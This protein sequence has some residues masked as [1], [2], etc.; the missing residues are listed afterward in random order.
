MSN[1]E[2]VKILDAKNIDTEFYFLSLLEQAKNAN[3]ITD[4][5]I[6]KIQSSCLL[7]LK[8]KLH[9]LTNGES[10]SVRT[11]VAE[12]IMKSNLYTVGVFLKSFTD[13]VDAL[14]LLKT[15]TIPEIYK[16]SK[17][18]IDRLIKN[19]KQL[20]FLVRKNLIKT[21]NFAYVSTIVAGIKGFFK[22][23]NAEFHANEIP[24]TCDYPTLIQVKNVVGIEFIERY[25]HYIYYENTFSNLF[26]AEQ[27]HYLLCGYDEHYEDLIF[28]IYEQILVTAMGIAILK[29]NVKSLYLSKVDVENIYLLF[30]EKSEKE[31]SVIVQS[32]FH[33][34]ITNLNINNKGLEKYILKSM[35]QLIS[36]IFIAID[37][38]TID[39]LFITSVKKPP[40]E[41]V[42]FSAGERMDDDKFTALVEEIM[43]CRFISDKLLLIRNEVFSLADLNDIILTAE[44]SETEMTEIL[45]TLEPPE[46]AAFIK[47]YLS[48]EEIEAEN[49]SEAEI[50]FS[51]SLREYF[52]SLPKKTQIEIARLLEKI[53]VEF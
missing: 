1:I 47:E 6:E 16:L 24:I 53:E 51:K 34:M 18:R 52:V 8:D 26:S 15:K 20:Y 3:L 44:L 33:F 41:Q 48:N 25:L 21:K 14:N 27:I 43:R 39:R 11:E 2:K 40:S 31:I 37:T 7:L 9:A 17:I 49:L 35:P 4:N 5:E 46:I 50:T 23:Y 45:A 13:P 28:N 19:S 29:G 36:D 38:D 10:G 12:S 42:V 30:S 22:C 32:A